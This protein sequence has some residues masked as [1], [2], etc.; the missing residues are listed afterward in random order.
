MYKLGRQLHSKLRGITHVA[1]KVR[2][3]LQ[4]FIVLTWMHDI[5]ELV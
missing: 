5:V 4:S 3:I 1:T 2:V